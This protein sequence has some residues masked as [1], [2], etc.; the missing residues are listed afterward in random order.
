M[1]FDDRALRELTVESQDLQAD[2]MHGVRAS[3]P[4]LR[5][6]ASDRRGQEIDPAKVD[7][8]NRTRRTLLQRLGLG[9][10]AA[11]ASTVF[12]GALAS[13]VATPASAD[14]A[15]DVQMLQTAS[16]LERL[17]S[18]TYKA[19]L[20]LPFIKSGNAVVVKFAQT[21]MM[22][23]DE[24]RKGFQDQT[25]AL[26]GKVQDSP[27]P[28]FQ[29]VVDA[30]LP[31]LKGPLDVVK[32]AAALEK[33]ATDTYL[34]DLTMFDDKKSIELMGSVMGVEAQHL[35]TLRAVQALLEGNAPELIA[36]PTDL[37]KLPKAAGSVAFP[38][39]FETTPDENIAEPE[40]G[41]IK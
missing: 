16:S 11:L 23:H 7:A 36:I 32:L 2:A 18:N 6:I 24:H 3:L 41:A 38:D 39:A 30:A 4:D 33:T 14:E 35:S 5:D 1:S 12:G 20:G 17:A 37:A 22:Q 27:N 19:A 15:L 9:T 34:V 31:G 10:G 21:T 29:K 28:K 8:F 40:T 26:G 13:I 25:T